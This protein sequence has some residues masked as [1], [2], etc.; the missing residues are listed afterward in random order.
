MKRMIHLTFVLLATGMAPLPTCDAGDGSVTGD[1]RYKY[2][3][4]DRLPEASQENAK[5]E[6]TANRQRRRLAPRRRHFGSH[7]Y[8]LRS[9]EIPWWPNAPGD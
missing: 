3:Q 4:R 9:A 6:R 7:W 8:Y 5:V 1:T 2:S